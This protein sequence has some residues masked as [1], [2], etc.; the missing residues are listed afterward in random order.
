M[1]LPGHDFDQ[2]DKKIV[3]EG[4]QNIKVFKVLNHFKFIK[5]E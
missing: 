1:D 3:I 5:N 4:S 2:L